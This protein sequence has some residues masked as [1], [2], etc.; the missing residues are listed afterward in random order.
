MAT[1][2]SMRNQ[3]TVQLV[4]NGVL[5]LAGVYL[6]SNGAYLVSIPEQ[7]TGRKIADS[8]R[9]GRTSTDCLEVYQL[10]DGELTSI[11]VT[12]ALDQSGTPD[13][14]TRVVPDN[15]GPFASGL[16]RLYRNKKSLGMALII[17]GIFVLAGPASLAWMHYYHK[18]R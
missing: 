12:A 15:S 6:I 18:R 5:A 13:G 3:T 10:E 11:P 1:N 7:R 14:V 17:V 8:C 4:V 16:L 2:G 9:P